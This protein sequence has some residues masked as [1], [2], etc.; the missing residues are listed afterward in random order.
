MS[1]LK[2]P[3]DWCIYAGNGLYEI[4]EGGGEVK[5]GAATSF[6]GL[7]FVCAKIIDGAYCVCVSGWPGVQHFLL[8]AAQLTILFVALAVEARAYQQHR[9]AV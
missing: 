5:T 3:R 4:T 2:T 6:T 8:S 7:W 9:T 1:V